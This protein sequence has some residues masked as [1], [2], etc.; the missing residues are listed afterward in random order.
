[1]K[2]VHLVGFITKKVLKNSVPRKITWQQNGACQATARCRPPLFC[3]Y[4]AIWRDTT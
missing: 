1:V 4:S 3:T 2:L